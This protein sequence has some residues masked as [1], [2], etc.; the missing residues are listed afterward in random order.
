ML[1][2]PP[3]R[4]DGVAV[5]VT[6]VPAQIAPDG[7]A[8]IVT[9][10]VT[11]AFTTMVSVFEFAVLLLKQ[12]PPVIVMVQVTVLPFA[13]EVEVKLFEAPLCT[14]LPLTLNS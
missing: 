12:P 7:E 8:A 4:S 2:V 11:L 10:G 5:K 13:R 1:T 3:P 9:V 6:D 14:V